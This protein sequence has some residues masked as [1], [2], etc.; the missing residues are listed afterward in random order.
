MPAERRTDPAAEIGT[1]I[2]SRVAS[3]VYWFVVIDALIVLTTAPGFLA[4]VFLDRGP[5]NA[6][7]IGLCFAPVAPALSAAV[8]AWRVF[9]HDRDLS[10]ATHFRRGYRLNWLDVLRWWL[11]TLAVLTV[12]GFSLSNLDL[13]AVPA[14]YGVVLVVIA[15]ALLVWS[16]QA[17]VLS[18]TL[19]LRTRDTARL[20]SYYLAA[21][22]ASALGALSLLIATGGL[23]TLTADWILAVLAAPFTLLLLRNADPVLRDATERFTA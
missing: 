1:G 6:P 7:L 21:R 18:S 15:A 4:L 16:T 19:A 23:V 10:P 8:Y 17:L 22:P 13:A 5:G 2:L 11:P 9:L 3:V 14:G 20:A 12:I